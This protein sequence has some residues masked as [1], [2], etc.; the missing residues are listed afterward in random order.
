MVTLKDG[1]DG[2]QMAVLEE[3]GLATGVFEGA[4]TTA[5]AL[6]EAV[7]AVLGVYEGERVD[8]LYVDQAR[9]NGAREA[10]ISTSVT[11]GA[12]IMAMGGPAKA[13]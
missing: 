1:H 7:P 2:Q 10:Q 6:D 13:P 12:A 5:L 4:I 9:A 3:T 11:F 8:I